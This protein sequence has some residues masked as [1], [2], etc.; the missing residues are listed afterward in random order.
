MSS[1]SNGNPGCL[2]ALFGLGR[3]GGGGARAA[4]ERRAEPLP[5]GLRDDF[6]SPA[7]KSFHDVLSI[8]L[9]SRLVVCPKVNLA[10]IFF[11]KRP[12]EN[13]GA[14][15]RISQKHLDFLL[16]EPGTMKPVLGIELDDSSHARAD[17]QERDAFVDQVYS[18]AGLPLLHIPVRAGY[19]IQ[20]LVS[21]LAPYVGREPI[22]E[23]LPDIESMKIPTDP[24]CPECGVPMVLRTS[25]RSDT[26]G[27]RFY[28]CPHYPKCRQVV[29]ID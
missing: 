12:N 28:G 1:S 2:G 14:R 25:G 9:E 15:S 19:S 11:V 10:D 23:T 13:T 27:S 8:A 16:C 4:Q 18:A 6:L 5:Y 3:A 17:R 21:M 7:E 24:H 20:E 26:K 29:P 22:R